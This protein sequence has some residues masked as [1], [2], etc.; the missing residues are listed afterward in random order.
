VGLDVS[1]KQNTSNENLNR[2]KRL[3]K[4][5]TRK[6]LENTAIYYLRRYSSSCENL[7]QVL[8][9]RVARSAQFN[10]VDVSE[11]QEWIHEI[12]EKLIAKNLLNDAHYAEIKCFSLNRS[13][14]SK[15]RIQKKLR[16]KGISQE[17][18][19]RVFKLLDNDTNEPELIAAAITARRRRLGPFRDGSNRMNFRLKDL[20][21][22]GRAG[23]SY[24][25]ANRIIDSE[26]ID[27]L[28]EKII[29]TNK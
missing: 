17:I 7:R 18:I 20:A 12:L 23:F 29:T 6:S 14:S 13:G 5:V 26:N 21:S 25:I 24:S 10:V 16:E 11:T 1:R 3:P 15:A 19:E 2:K 27:Q 22:L 28:E 8:R 9:R 4:K